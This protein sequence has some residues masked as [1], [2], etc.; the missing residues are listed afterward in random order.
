MSPTSYQAAPPRINRTDVSRRPAWW[1]ADR[2]RVRSSRET[3][4]PERVAPPPVGW[5]YCAAL[6]PGRTASSTDG[7]MSVGGNVRTRHGI[8]PAVLALALA[9]HVTD[10]RAAAEVHRLN[11]V[12]SAVPTQVK[13]TD[14]NNVIGDINSTLLEPIG[15]EP[16]TTIKLS[17]M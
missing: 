2:A 8:I 6:G 12:L 15:L 3:P 13:A 5:L 1:Q 11:V 7:A 17:W 16:L 4:S 9:G 10:A 14:F